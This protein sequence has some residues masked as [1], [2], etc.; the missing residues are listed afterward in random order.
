M[1][2]FWM[3]CGCWWSC[4]SLALPYYHLGWNGCCWWGRC[5]DS[6]DVAV[7]WPDWSALDIRIACCVYVDIIGIMHPHLFVWISTLKG[8]HRGWRLFSFRCCLFLNFTAFYIQCA[9]LLP[10]V[11]LTV[12]L[13]CAANNGSWSGP[14]IQISNWWR[15]RWWCAMIRIVWFTFSILL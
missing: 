14:N 7:E 11:S 3:S 8:I 1:D 10:G 2:S 15:S 4:D 5:D 12:W 13:H 6:M 9:L